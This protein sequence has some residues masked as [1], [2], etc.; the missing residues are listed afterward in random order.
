V[1][2]R[3]TGESIRLRVTPGELLALRRG[4][5]LDLSIAFPGGGGWAVAVDPDGAASGLRWDD[6]LVVVGLSGRD[7]EHLAEPDR[8]G[9][10]FSGTDASGVR[11]LVEKDFPCAHPHPEEAA[12]PE[13]ERF[14]P[15]AT[16]LARKERGA[17]DV[18]SA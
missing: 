18:R 12:E 14:E 6:G 16:Y 15:T 11:V 4:E 1:K 9:I 17:V 2:V 13:T 10:Y 7:V 3:W 5:V 8:E